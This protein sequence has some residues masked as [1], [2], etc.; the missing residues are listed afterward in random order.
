MT[1]NYIGLMRFIAISSIVIV[2]CFLLFSLTRYIFSAEFQALDQ[3]SENISIDYAYIIAPKDMT[4][5]QAI[6]ELPNFTKTDKDGVPFALKNQAYWLSLKINKFS[7]ALDTIIIHAKNA[8][9]RDLQ[10]IEMKK[11]GEVKT[12]FD[13]TKLND[14]NVKAKIFP[15][16]RINFEHG[17]HKHLLIKIYTDGPPD[18]PLEFYSEQAFAERVELSQ[19]IFGCF[20]GIFILMAIYNLVFYFAVKNKIYLLYV[21]YLLAVFFTLS[22][23][24]G[25][26]FYLFDASIQAF[27]NDYIIS[28]HYLLMIF[29]LVFTVYFLNYEQDKTPHFKIS[30]IIAGAIFILL[31]A[32]ASLH[33][34]L[35]AKI[36]F[37]TVPVFFIYLI[38]IVGRKLRVSFVWSRYYFLS[39]IPLIIGAT[40]QPL[41]H[42]NIIESGFVSG[43]AFLF[44]VMIEVIFLA[45]A[46]AERMKKTEQDRLDDI[47]YHIDTK[48]PRKGNLEMCLSEQ[49]NKGSGSLTVVVIKP[50]HIEKISLYISDYFNNQFFI[51]LTNAINSLVKFNDAVLPITAKNEKIA[52]IEPYSIGLILNENDSS[53][54]L[55]E[56][57]K[58]IQYKV[59]DSYK[60]KELNLPLF[61]NVG[62]SNYPHNNNN[63]Q[64]LIN[65]A[66]LASNKATDTLGGWL[67]FDSQS[68]TKD[69]Y[70][71]NLASHMSDAIDNDEFEI[72][73][74]PQ[75]DLKTLRVCGSECLLRWY[76]QG[77]GFVSPAVFVPIA[78]DI[79]LIKKLTRWVIKRS[80]LQH[81]QI[82]LNEH[83]NHMVSIN[84]S[85]KDIT[86]E[87]IVPFVKKSLLE[88]DIPADK[89]ILEL[90]E[91]TA[92]M[93]N[94]M[95]IKI[96]EELIELGITMSIDDFG[97]GYSS[98]S[99]MSQLP[100]QELKVDREFVENIKD[101]EKNKIICETT[102]KMAKG[103]K[104]E[105]VAE[106][107]NSK[108]DENILREFGC[109]IGQGFYYA[110]PMPIDQYL[111]WLEKEVNGQ[112][113]EDEVL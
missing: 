56:F 85:G 18:V 9:L 84:I 97:T 25:F 41:D 33:N 107:I 104:L 90:T 13:I 77:E 28:T 98:M 94:P 76:Y 75:I 7:P 51:D 99:Y 5:N 2:I 70:L 42:T 113:P 55:E 91:S 17:T 19:L 52:F 81:K 88:A 65:E 79:G 49:I 96:M 27:L 71:L 6:D 53:Q 26:G 4:L 22:S 80:L 12:L 74:Q 101:H 108:S 83:K 10:I 112:L 36:Y 95:G 37:A 40:I 11:N 34:T 106:G 111:A 35:E 78:E 72:F 105:V 43:H 32:T 23:I 15:H 89:V 30:M 67:L 14:K 69:D 100:C 92:I 66:Q 82:M 48:L 29:L 87:E 45:F 59:N 39:W 86:D 21:G 50:E 46:L 109:D 60:V 103:L 24:N 62:L 57:V 63:P 110:K 93:N 58:S 54:S 44:A 20:I 68:Q 73:H 38:Y 8:M 47:C 31:V 1:T 64:A 102:I 61:A 16:A 3:S